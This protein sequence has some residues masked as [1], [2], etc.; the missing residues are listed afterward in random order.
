MASRCNNTKQ[1]KKPNWATAEGKK[2]RRKQKRG[3]I[4]HETTASWKLHD[5][6][7]LAWKDPDNIALELENDLKSFQQSLDNCG[8]KT[9]KDSEKIAYIEAMVKI[10]SKLSQASD[11]NKA[12]SNIVIAE[13][14]SDRCS[15]FHYELSSYVQAADVHDSLKTLS[16]LCEFC[17]FVVHSFRGRSHVLPI[18]DL[19]NLSSLPALLV[20]EMQSLA[21]IEKEYLLSLKK[22]KKL[23]NDAKH[24]LSFDPSFFENWDD[25][26]FRNMSILP[27]VEEVTGKPLPL[28][29]NIIK[30]H[31]TGW[32]QYYDIQFRLLREDFV[33]PLRRGISEY[34][35]PQKGQR[36][37]EVYIYNN[38]QI[39]NPVCTQEGLCYDIRIDLRELNLRQG[40]EQSKRLMFGSLLCFST[41]RFKKEMYFCIVTN[42]EP[43]SI[44]RGIVQVKFEDPLE[45][46]KHVQK[47]R[48]VV[49]ESRAFFEGSRHILRSLQLAEVDTMPFTRYLVLNEPFEQKPLPR[50]LNT[51]NSSYNLQAVYNNDNPFRRNVDI[52]EASDW[53][54]STDHD[55]ELD[56]S[57]LDAIK[58]A[59]TQEIA[60]IQGP[61]GTGKTYIG[62]KIVQAL[63]EN[64][65]VWDP[66]LSTS[67]ILVMC[68]TNHAL[69]QFLEGIIHHKIQ[70]VHSKR[71]PKRAPKIVRIGGRS[72]SE[73]IQQFSLYNV[74]RELVPKFE[75][76]AVR[77]EKNQCLEFGSRVA[78]KGQTLQ[79]II[80]L[81]PSVVNEDGMLNLKPFI[82]PSHFYQILQL[83][84]SDEEMRY[85][86]EIWL[87]LW[88]KERVEVNKLLDE[89]YMHPDDLSLA[90]PVDNEDK[91]DV[92]SIVHE[93]EFEEETRKLDTDD[94][95]PLKAI[96]EAEHN[97]DNVLTNLIKKSKNLPE[98]QSKE[99]FVWKKKHPRVIEN[100]F[101]DIE[102]VEPLDEYND[103]L[104][105]DVTHWSFKM[106]LR[107]QLLRFWLNKYEQ[108]L[109][110]GS[111]IDIKVFNEM[112]K[113]SKKADQNLDRI[114]LEKAEV[115]GMTTT[116]AAKYQ[117]IIHLVKPKIVIVE[118]AAELLESH[119]VSALNAGTQHL[120]L[121]GDHK[122][123]RPK[124]NEYDL[125]MKHNLHISLFERL[126]L[127]GLPHATLMIQHRMRPQIAS[128]VCPHIYDKLINHE[129]V[130]KYNNVRGFRKNM[131]F[132]HH[133]QEEQHN[134]QALSHANEY[135]AQFIVAL[136]RHLLKLGYEPSQVTILTAYSGQLL[137]L[138]NMMPK[139]IF[140]GV[141]IT[142]VDNFQGEENDIIILSLVRNN[143]RGS[144]GFLKEE[145][146][147]CVALSRA[148]MGF[149]CFGNFNKLLRVQVPIWNKI[150]TQVEEEG[151]L[152]SAFPLQCPN[153]DD[154]VFDVSNPED[155][156]KHAPEGGCGKPCEYRL[157][158]GHTCKRF[159]HGD[160]LD[161]MKY[162]C[163]MPC[164]R[165]CEEGHN[166]RYYCYNVPCPPCMEIV[167]KSLP[168]G[169]TNLMKCCDD[170]EK[171]L[172][173]KKCGKLC[174]NGQHKCPLKCWKN[175]RIFGCG[176]CSFSVVK[177]VPQCGD[178]NTMPCYQN[179]EDFKCGQICGK[180][181]CKDKH[182]CP[183]EC[184]EECGSCETMVQKKLPQCTHTVELPC[185]VDPS[186]HVC[187]EKCSKKYSICS[188]MCQK[189]CSEKCDPV[190][191]KLVRRKLK[192]DHEQTM[193][194]FQLPENWTCKEQCTEL[195]AKCGHRCEGDCGKPCHLYPCKVM[196]ELPLPCGH[197]FSVECS[198]AIMMRLKAKLGN[199]ECYEKCK[200]KLQCR[201]P[202]QNRCSEPCTVKCQ[203]IEDR[204][205]RKG[206]HTVKAVCGEISSMCEKKCPRK[207][208][209]EHSCTNK[210]G[211]D[212]I[213]SCTAEIKDFPCS[214]GHSH[215]V[216]CNARTCKC[217][218]K[219]STILKCGHKCSGKCG[220]CF[221]SRIH[222]PCPFEVHV[223]RFCGHHG[224]VPCFG[225]EDQCNKTCQ[226]AA[227]LHKPTS[228]CRHKCSEPCDTEC[229]EPCSYECSHK[230]CTQPCSSPCDVIPCSKP[231]DKPLEC[232]H[233]CL[234]IC[235]EKCL[236][237]CI[238]CNRK[239]FVSSV[240]GLEKKAKP[241]S[242]H[243]IELNCGHFFTVA[244]LAKYYHPQADKDRLVSPLLCPTC[245]KIITCS[246]YMGLTKE[247]ERE[248]KCVKLRRTETECAMSVLEAHCGEF[249][250]ALESIQIREGE[251][252]SYLR[253]LRDRSYTLNASFIRKL[254]ENTESLCTLDLLTAICKLCRELSRESSD[255][256]E[257][258]AGLL[259]KVTSVTVERERRGLSLQ[260]IHD[261]KK[262][263]YR[264]TL[265]FLVEKVKDALKKCYSATAKGTKEFGTVL[266]ILD[267][268]ESNNAILN[269]D[270]YHE[271]VHVLTSVY[272]LYSTEVLSVPVD[273]DNI[274]AP[275]ITKGQWYCCAI[276]GHY[277][278]VPAKYQQGKKA[279][280]CDQCL[281]RG[282]RSIR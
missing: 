241:E 143:D 243:Y 57:Q 145:N 270:I 209:C 258:A 30:G 78:G 161:H 114:A 19:I 112:C 53:P 234:G 256:L 157:D 239:A 200:K 230:K 149:Y 55:V 236:S 245:Q 244:Y 150:S 168:C 76:Q 226:V 206:V 22:Q 106:S 164:A 75:Y 172:C 269:R 235:G 264:I 117:H 185:H 80:Q 252:M 102:L 105:P 163:K 54:K 144:V 279:T 118:E 42:R 180:V 46:L 216:I 183:K 141:K 29:S 59:L 247:K 190:C 130:M 176:D 170:P 181:L 262:E 263:M 108:S 152:G 89:E 192:C 202:C 88:R 271:C 214:C 129:S 257:T 63:L 155:F 83:A 146:R 154:F 25:S 220:D 268:T 210:C 43:R 233:M 261:I 125:A 253:L 73:E 26:Q 217:Q 18:R 72:K 248:I 165:E 147:V 169:H 20:E 136:C 275:I 274:E 27:S 231:C 138:M 99:E 45:M 229:D 277:Y 246:Q 4:S 162:Q 50:Y 10:V 94:Y 120:I 115:I 79:R 197:S 33:A 273:I 215:K 110:I 109:R 101:K 92:I 255:L 51:T 34:C 98:N 189:T 17:N 44:R 137:K 91:E 21:D 107:Y 228:S 12:S 158:C 77:R 119:I 122:Q 153:H 201:H 221:T 71:A 184:W 232:G 11:D 95:T 70:G 259:K 260:L 35:N 66:G 238:I 148:R 60:I 207:L 2:Q 103:D 187:K 272:R 5:I 132:F 93:V 178:Y 81:C 281:S 174:K 9:L 196:K 254:G 128:L 140:E 67:P 171:V 31:Y 159:C 49:V 41:D 195:L 142:N 204:K 36:I 199:I 100:I 38:V 64:K 267:R 276:A 47:T 86:L 126:I 173:N 191:M 84:D 127:N 68:F 56:Q 250:K 14:L 212:C 28:K 179:P 52:L 208:S 82:Y 116:G 13:F 177:E 24:G 16:M 194:C 227:C 166:C 223:K 7:I 74:R 96:E 225:L 131:Y 266:N 251:N 58:M 156:A 249:R 48:F 151:C 23:N 135:E 6:E 123:L 65:H 61:P 87:G 69:D 124:P 242:S 198:K 167:T 62:Y 8:S 121:I 39:L 282:N 265:L 175:C 280:E 111:D 224:T 222:A 213:E 237:R 40:I 85:G 205:C 133:E 240:K 32:E 278:F 211:E 218:K 182:T 15:K 139:N 188:H 1:R 134:Q 160:D 97:H 104:I 219:C 186:E 90:I 3:T 113:S 193:P 37:T 203:V